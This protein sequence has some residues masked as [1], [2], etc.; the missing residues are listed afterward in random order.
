MKLRFFLLL[1]AVLA[2]IA[3]CIPLSRNVFFSVIV[4]DIQ[5]I[6]ESE[7]DSYAFK[8]N[9]KLPLRI[10]IVGESGSNDKHSFNEKVL[11]QLLQVLKERQVQLIFFTGNLFENALKGSKGKNDTTK[12]FKTNL[13]GFDKAIQSIFHHKIFFFPILGAQDV[14]SANAADIFRTQFNLKK[15][16]P[17][18]QNMLAYTISIDDAFFAVIPTDYFDAQHGRIVEHSMPSALLQWLQKTLTEASATHKYL[19]VLGNEPAF[20]TPSFSSIYQGLDNDIVQRDLFWKTLIDQGVLAYFSA[21]EHLFDRS[22][23]KGV[24]QIISGGGGAPLSGGV[25]AF[26]H[27]LL[28]TIP[29]EQGGVPKI[30]VLDVHGDVR[31]MFEL[32]PQHSPLYQ[33]RISYLY[34]T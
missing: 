7:N 15:S 17:F 19:F 21:Q 25:N 1:F 31:D 22:N 34:R 5:E 20:S 14:V 10:G 32:T 3:V 12:T 6:K 13:K 23:R 28:L 30:E 2:V 24:W 4:P 16:S 18:D 33:L 27:C 9:P 26:F 29:R 11:S 8:V